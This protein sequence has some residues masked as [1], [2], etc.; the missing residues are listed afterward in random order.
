MHELIM[1][2]TLAT[3]LYA[4]HVPKHTSSFFQQKV[5]NIATTSLRTLVGLELSSRASSADTTV[6]KNL[7][8]PSQNDRFTTIGNDMKVCKLLNGSKYNPVTFSNHRFQSTNV[9]V[10]SVASVWGTWV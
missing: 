8:L 9:F 3:C 7:I 10:C 4:N 5:Q 1:S 6:P 2:M